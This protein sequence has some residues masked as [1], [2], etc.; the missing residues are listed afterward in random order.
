M[1]IQDFLITLY[2]TVMMSGKMMDKFDKEYLSTIN[3]AILK[4]KFRIVKRTVVENVDGFGGPLYRV[5][6]A[7][8]MGHKF[9]FWHWWSYVAKD[10]FGM[11]SWTTSLEYCKKW[12]YNKCVYWDDKIEVVGL[13]SSE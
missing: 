12:I 9:L 5:E 8:Q 6:Y 2:M 13:L 11:A 1:Q 3:D 7:V 10:E 4:Q